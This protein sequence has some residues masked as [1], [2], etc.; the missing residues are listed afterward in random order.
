MKKK[1]FGF[2]LVFLFFGAGFA[3]S[4][5]KYN[6]QQLIYEGVDLTRYVKTVTVE[7]DGGAPTIRFYLTDGE[8]LSVF[9][10]EKDITSRAR[11]GN[12]FECLAQIM[13]R[14]D[15]ASSYDV[16]NLRSSGSW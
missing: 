4:Q 10:I 14:G 1:I 2:C 15:S 5:T 16:R 11:A 6:C 3:F 8:K 13:T 12:N 7:G 9:W